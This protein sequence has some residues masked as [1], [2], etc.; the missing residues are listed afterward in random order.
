MSKQR[1]VVIRRAD[2]AVIEALKMALAQHGVQIRRDSHFS[3]VGNKS[4]G[5]VEVTAYNNA[6]RVFLTDPEGAFLKILGVEITTLDGE[7]LEEPR[8]VSLRNFE[9]SDISLSFALHLT[10]H[11]TSVI[12]QLVG[13]ADGFET[14]AS[15]LHFLWEYPIVSMDGEDI[16]LT[17]RPGE[18]GISELVLWYNSARGYTHATIRYDEGGERRF[19]CNWLTYVW[20]EE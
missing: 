18:L 12:Y 2:W 9:G 10:E 19:R 5:V 11:R 13:V 16:K 6:G 7:V 3:I 8:V 14:A 15:L 1:I 17:Y 4:G 20:T